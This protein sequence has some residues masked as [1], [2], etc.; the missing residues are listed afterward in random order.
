MEA[1][2][3]QQVAKTILAAKNVP[4]F[5]AAPMLIQDLQSWERNGMQG[6]QV[7][8]WEEAGKQE[9]RRMLALVTTSQS[10][11]RELPRARWPPAELYMFASWLNTK[12]GKV[13]QKD[14]MQR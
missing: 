7:C 14:I 10:S 13:I 5:V 2:R 8:P 4:Y 1:G 3:Q 11:H 12:R 6:L 9:V